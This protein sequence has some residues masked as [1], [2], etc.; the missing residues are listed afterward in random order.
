[1]NVRYRVT[2]TQDERGELAALLNGGKQPARKLKRA[3][4][5]LAADAGVGDE[6]QPLVR[7]ER[8]SLRPSADMNLPEECRP[9]ESDHRERARAPAAHVEPP[10]RGIERN[11]RRMIGERQLHE[12]HRGGCRDRSTLARK[13]RR[14]TEA[15]H[16]RLELIGDVSLASVGSEG[17]IHGTFPE[18][19]EAHGLEQVAVDERERRA[20][21]T[22]HRNPLPVRR[23]PHGS[24]TGCEVDVR[25]GSPGA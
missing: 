22:R 23:D 17:E 4:I 18:G 3:Q 20:E 1:M 5:L 12:S 13:A 10:P 24:R 14:R 21:I 2:L 11:A 6:E 25:D 15:I 7:C 16:R 8:E 19:R 9:R